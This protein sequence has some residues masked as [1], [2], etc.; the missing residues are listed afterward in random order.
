M[1]LDTQRL[2]AHL[3]KAK[4]QAPTMPKPPATPAKP[5][6][7]KQAE[8]IEQ[9]AKQATGVSKVEREVTNHTGLQSQAN[10]LESSQD[11][12]AV[13]EASLSPALLRKLLSGIKLTGDDQK[14][15]AAVCKQIG[16][17]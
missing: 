6:S 10:N 8:K 5:A 9:Q 16:Y 13:A 4:A 1:S 17:L 7:I 15:V 12:R 14:A 3:M 11:A 2:F